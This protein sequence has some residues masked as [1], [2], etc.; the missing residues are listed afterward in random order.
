VVQLTLEGEY[1]RTFVTI[2][3]A[4]RAMNSPEGQ[5]WIRNAALGRTRSAYRSLWMTRDAYE[6]NAPQPVYTPTK[7]RY[8]T[9]K[10]QRLDQSGAVVAEYPSIKEAS[11]ATGIGRNHIARLCNGRVKR[12]QYRFRYKS[13]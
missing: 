3:E 5:K 9:K 7:T 12:T 6:A 4:A 8:F 13:E 10:V 11:V 1:I 2:S